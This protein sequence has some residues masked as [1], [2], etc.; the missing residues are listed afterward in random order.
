MTSPRMDWCAWF[1]ILALLEARGQGARG[2]MQLVEAQRHQP[3]KHA[4]CLFD[5]T[6]REIQEV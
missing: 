3:I 5:V 4:M 2:T 6:L 1:A